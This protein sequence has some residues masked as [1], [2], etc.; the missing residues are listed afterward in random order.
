MQGKKLLCKRVM[1]DFS[2]EQIA[3]LL[4]IHT[5]TYRLKEVGKK[6]LRLVK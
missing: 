3:N 5:E 1:C 4:N 6:N 2:K